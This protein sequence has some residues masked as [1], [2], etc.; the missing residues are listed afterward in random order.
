MSSGIDTPLALIWL[1]LPPAA[2]ACCRLL[3]QPRD[4]LRIERIIL[5]VLE[6]RLSAPSCY[7]F[8]HL[9]AQACSSWVSPSVLSL[10]M[11]LCEL[12]MLDPH[13]HSFSHSR[14]AASALLLAQVSLGSAQHT[15]HIKAAVA[16]CMGMHSLQGL[17]PCMMVLLRLQQVA[18]KPAVP[19][20]ATAGSGPQDMCADMELASGYYAMPPAAAA[21]GSSPASG[22]AECDYDEPHFP[23]SQGSLCSGVLGQTC[24]DQQE[25]AARASTLTGA[26]AAFAPRAHHQE[27]QQQTDDLLAPIRLK[28]AQQEWCSVSGVTPLTLLPAQV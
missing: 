21:A 11:F 27:Q 2:A 9:L 23:S 28:F 16:S 10:A 24:F 20:A 18:A 5:N 6:F 1:L 7:T 17:G 19:P 13:A 4:L 25:P 22:V 8:L 15:Q 3:P 14:T 26:S 12:A